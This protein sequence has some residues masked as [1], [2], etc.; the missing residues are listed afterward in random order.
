MTQK[1]HLRRRGSELTATSSR[2]PLLRSL[3]TGLTK[4]FGHELLD[5][6]L[7]AEAAVDLSDAGTERGSS[8]ARFA[9]KK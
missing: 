4:N 5:R 8:A 6:G 1:E 2:W 9:G 3:E 7:L